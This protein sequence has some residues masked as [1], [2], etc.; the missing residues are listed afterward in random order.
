MPITIMLV[1]DDEALRSSLERWLTDANFSVVSVGDGLKV[2]DLYREA[3]PNLILMDIQMPGLSGMDLQDRLLSAGH[4]M[5]VSRSH[6][7]VPTEVLSTVA[8]LAAEGASV[9]VNYLR[10]DAAAAEV[11]A[12]CRRLGGEIVEAD[13]HPV[14]ALLDR[15]ADVP[16]S[17]RG[18][19]AALSAELRQAVRAAEIPD[20]VVS[21]ISG[22]ITGLGEGVACAVR[23][24][25]TS[26]DSPAASF[27]GQHDSY[28]DVVG[29]AA[30]LEHVRRCWASLFTERAVTYRLRNG[31]DHKKVSKIDRISDHQVRFVLA[32]RGE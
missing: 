6:V 32:E 7:S 14:G 19:I 2:V 25:A 5:V 23:S 30:I 11:V 16:A 17:D 13:L 28:L 12:E 26:E 9:I 27:A 10:S 15:L 21:A 18:I 24:S 20:D 1:E 3:K 31:V 8:T 29:M 22:A 4:E